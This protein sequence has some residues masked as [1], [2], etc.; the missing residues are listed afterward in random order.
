M[1]SPM[2]YAKQLDPI[3]KYAPPRVRE[4]AAST[5]PSL[6]HEDPEN[7]P[8]EKQDFE[9]VPTFDDQVIPRLSP[10]FALEPQEVPA[11]PEQH[12][13]NRG[14]W[15][16]VLRV[17]G[18]AG[19]AALGAWFM[20]WGPTARE[21]AREGLPATV[22]PI[23][24]N[25][26]K[27]DLLL[28][29]KVTRRPERTDFASD[30][31]QQVVPDP[32]IQPRVATASGGSDATTITLAPPATAPQPSS[33]VQ[34]AAPVQS[35]TMGSAAPA[36]SAAPVQSAAPPLVIKQLDREEVASLIKRGEDLIASEDLSSARLLLRR[37]A[38]AG[39]AQAA[40][41]LAGTFDPN[42]LEKFRV[43]RLAAD[44][45]QARLWYQRAEQL[46]SAEATRR[47]QQLAT[48]SDH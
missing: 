15:K 30:S 32:R 38:E 37:A 10:A 43:K 19:L 34:P 24:G 47:L 3:L 9:S 13:N 2:R 6:P 40:L 12:P 44:V 1:S 41:E 20:V 29:A 4:Q 42:L 35:A 26:N 25:L 11:P 27:Q 18:V 8:P 22:L 7:W 39:A 33:L 14:L 5:Q 17:C 23:V 46:G 21:F 31:A 36:Q 45:T 28:H 48:A 16:I